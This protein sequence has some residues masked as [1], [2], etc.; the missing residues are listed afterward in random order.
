VADEDGF[1]EEVPKIWQPTF[2][3]TRFWK[4]FSAWYQTQKIYWRTG[5]NQLCYHGG[6]HGLKRFK[7]IVTF[8][9]IQEAYIDINDTEA[10]F[11]QQAGCGSHTSH[12]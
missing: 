3:L 6:L 2:D 11:C 9:K 8:V 12:G 1:K 10:K 7:F 4:D 5:P